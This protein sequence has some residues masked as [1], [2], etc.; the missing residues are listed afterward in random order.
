MLPSLDER[1]IQCPYCGEQISVLVDPSETGEQYVEDCQVC[2][3]PIEFM[4]SE[5]HDG[6]LSIHVQTDHD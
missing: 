3:R 5:G 6:A 1:D 4:L 2:C